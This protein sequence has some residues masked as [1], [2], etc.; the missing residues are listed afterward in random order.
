MDQAG[1]PDPQNDESLS[2]SPSIPDDQTSDAGQASDDASVDNPAVFNG[3]TVSA[4][5]RPSIPRLNI[6]EIAPVSKVDE[7]LD[8]KSKNW[9][10]WLQSMDLLFS[11]ANCRGYIDGRTRCP[12]A[13]A[14][15][16][17][18][19]NWEF[20]D[21]YIRV[22][23]RK[24]IATLQKMHTCG[25]L[26]SQK[27]WNNLCHIHKTTNY[28]VHTEKIRTICAVCLQ[29]NS[30]VVEHLTKL[31]HTWEQC[32]F[33][34]HLARIYD[35]TFFKQQIAASL[36]RSW[37]Q[38]TCP[39]V[40][41]CKDQTE[42]DKDPK[43]KIDSQEFISLICQEYE[44]IQSHKENE[45]A[46]PLK[47][48]NANPSLA[49]HISD[50]SSEMNRSLKKKCKCRHC[51]KNSH[52][53]DQCRYLGK[54]KCCNCGR[55]RHDLDKCPDNDEDQADN[56]KRKNNC[57]GSG[58]NKRSCQESNNTN[59]DALSANNALHGQLV[60]LHAY[61]E[62]VNSN[63]DEYDS[64]VVSTQYNPVRLYDWLGDSGATCHITWERDAFSTYETI[65][66]TTISGVGDVKMF[67][68]R[69]GTVYL[70]SKCDGITH[71]LQLNNILH[72]PNN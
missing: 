34:G 56:S 20:N 24:N 10:A 27:M 66:K 48:E 69:R 5:K 40:K 13:N 67:A 3:I 36:L 26:T 71:T 1:P 52:F 33:T 30:N 23:I 59:D 12:N 8:S 64:Y 17:G 28:L 6:V 57:S 54:N 60:G 62:P 53:T 32:S 44:Y 63:D 68:I 70:H 43:L 41:E 22:L 72:V 31:K 42:A 39:Y 11:I 45:I 47:G 15:P 38:F 14:D 65:L 55:F 51:G 58:S 46:I 35:D 61:I 16:I 49:N 7:T 29:E 50:P 4:P 37:D 9:T 18:F 19:Q 2:S 25:C 21:S